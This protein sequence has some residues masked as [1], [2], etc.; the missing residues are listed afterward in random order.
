MSQLLI[1]TN[2][3]KPKISSENG[4]MFVEGILATCEKENGNGRY[5][6]K[7]LWEREIE[8]F[9]EKINQ[10]TT[11][12]CGELDHAENE[13][14]NLKNLSHAIRKVWWEGNKIM[15]LLEIFCDLGEKGTAA[16]RIA[17]AII[18]NGLL[19]GVSS[20]GLGSLKEAQNGVLEVQDDFSLLTWDFVS[21][22]SNPNS[23]MKTTQLNESQSLQIKKYYKVNQIIQ[24]ILCSNG[25]CPLG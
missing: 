3:F 9:Q 15:G 24:D 10:K 16:G 12:S 20:R 21:N 14:I 4:N 23:W 18:K 2:L 22:P 6:R 1:E 13:I 11:E 7:E 25:N 19:L 5:Y 17:G 8:K